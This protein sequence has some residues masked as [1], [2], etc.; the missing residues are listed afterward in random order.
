[1]FIRNAWYVVAWDFEVLPDSILERTVR[2]ESIIVYRTNAGAPVVMENRCCHRAAPLSL[3][4]K[5]GDCI[6]CMYHGLR[7]DPS[8]ACVEIPGQ[9]RI[10]P[11]ARVRTYPAVQR[12]RWIWVWMG[13]RDSMDERQIPNTFSVQHADWRTKP[14]YK[15]FAANILLLADNL[16]DFAHL[17]FV[18]EKTLGGTPVIAE[19]HAEVSVEDGRLIRVVRRL[20]DTLVAPYHQRFGHFTGKV[21]RWWDYTLSVSGMFIM[22]S[23]L[24]SAQKPQGDLEGA[25]LF[26]SCQALTPETGSSTHYFFSHAHN[27]ALDDPTVTESI[28]Q[29]I[30]EAFD[31]D[32]RMI[33]AQRRV[34]DR[35]PDREMVGIAADGALIRYRRLV[36]AALAVERGRAPI[37]STDLSG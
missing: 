29:S 10:P 5:E 1:M 27:F 33:E 30:V 31:E 22:S 2:D 3:G 14:G 37:S 11:T 34:I 26:H 15:I 4:R 17:S 8:G 21:N 32:R 9:Q 35:T 12:N 13:E 24:Q 18:H 19:T 20:A 36:H 7:F 23:G 25:L 28:Y 16:L 6:R